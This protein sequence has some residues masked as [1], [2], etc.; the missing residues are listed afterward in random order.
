[1]TPS[2]FD[3]FLAKWA[4]QSAHYGLPYR[5]AWGSVGPGWI[6]LLDQL[7]TDLVALG[8]NREVYQ[9]KEKFGGLRFY[10]KSDD[11]YQVLRPVLAAAEAKS[12]TICEHCGAPGELNRTRAWLRTLCVP[13][14]E[15]HTAGLFTE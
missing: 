7:C 10:A 1:M 9:I 6:P 15:L 11:N 12:L 13:C 5:A 4:L 2:A 3:A 14:G 8:W